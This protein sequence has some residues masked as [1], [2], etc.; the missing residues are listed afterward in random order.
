[1]SDTDKAGNIFALKELSSIKKT[2]CVEVLKSPFTDSGGEMVGVRYVHLFLFVWL[3]SFVCIFVLFSKF[4]N[5]KELV[6][7]FSDEIDSVNEELIA[8]INEEF[9]AMNRE[10]RE[11]NK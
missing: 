6:A 9:E 11:L 8:S 2:P 1:M 5:L 10:L 3:A 4:I 7:G